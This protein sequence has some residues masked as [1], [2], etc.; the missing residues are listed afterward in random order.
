MYHKV[1]L[2]CKIILNCKLI[3]NH[4]DIRTDCR[5]NPSKTQSYTCVTGVLCHCAIVVYVAVT[6]SC[7]L[8]AEELRPVDQT[9][10][11]G[12]GEE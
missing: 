2:N 1:Y 5:L 8:A 11:A 12:T 3:L 7:T 9:L 6:D 4:E 10:R